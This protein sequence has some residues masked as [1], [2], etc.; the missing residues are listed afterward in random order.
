MTK[1]IVWKW[2]AKF[3][4]KLFSK[5]YE[6]GITQAELSRATGINIQRVNRYT[7]GDITPSAIDILK[8]A[9]V[10]ECTVNELIEFDGLNMLEG[11]DV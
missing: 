7:L 9:K 5:M 4:K 10:L 8:I 6:I 1:P 2:R 11:D 3:A